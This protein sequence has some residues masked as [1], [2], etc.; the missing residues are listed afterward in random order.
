MEYTMVGTDKGERMKKS[1][2]AIVFMMICMTGCATEKIEK[3][4]EPINLTANI[5]TEKTQAESEHTEN[6]TSEKATETTQMPEEA[7]L[8][9][10][11]QSNIRTFYGKEHEFLIVNGNEISKY[12]LEKGKTT[13]TKETEWWCD[14]DFFVVDGGYCALGTTSDSQ[15]KNRLDDVCIFYNDKLE[16]Q[17]RVELKSLTE[18]MLLATMN[19]SSDGSKIACFDIWNGLRFYDVKTGKI[20]QVLSADHLD[21]ILSMDVL[22]FNNTNDAVIF[23]ADT[24][25]DGASVKSWG[26]INIDGTGLENH[27]LEKEAGIPLAFKNNN[28]LYGE[29]SLMFFGKMGIVKTDTEEQL[30]NT[31][32]ET[33]R[34]IGG[35]YFSS[36]GGYFASAKMGDSDAVI[37]IYSTENFE[38]VFQTKI[39]DENKG[40]FYRVPKI[41]I[42]DSMK[43]CIVYLGGHD[44]VPAKVELIHF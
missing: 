39:Q 19:V 5:S 29:D 42:L 28:L 33:G 17:S 23:S 15:M 16:E 7:D 41:Y 21:Q 31:A 40:L 24:N 14:V 2:L 4:D 6:S 1:I 26:K 30:Y 44:E 36:D 38:Q 18:D 20:S 27:I 25:Q 3:T 35:P 10:F 13:V 37:T 9:V 32:I 8:S 34:N 11:N 12:D 22:Y 43:V